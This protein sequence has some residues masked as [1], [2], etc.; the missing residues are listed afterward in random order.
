M[1][2]SS[3]FLNF[4]AKKLL[5]DESLTLKEL[6]VLPQAKAKASHHNSPSLRL[7]QECRF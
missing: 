1:A 4:I 5:F 6:T 2:V 3:H 7:R